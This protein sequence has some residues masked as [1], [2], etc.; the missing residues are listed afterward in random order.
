MIGAEKSHIPK[1]LRMQTLRLRSVVLSMDISGHIA[2][3]HL[4]LEVKEHGCEIWPA[5]HCVLTPQIKQI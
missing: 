5:N 4:V 3:K 1:A 2:P